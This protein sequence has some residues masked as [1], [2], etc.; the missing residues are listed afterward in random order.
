MKPSTDATSK[1]HPRRSRRWL[2]FSLRTFLLVVAALAV[3]LGIEANQARKQKEAIDRILSLGGSI[4]FDFQVSI[5]EGK[6]FDPNTVPPGPTWLRRLIP[7]EYLDEVTAVNFVRSPVSDSD[8]EVLEHLPR[9]EQVVISECENVT[10]TGFSYLTGLE[11][12]RL[13]NIHATP[14]TDDGLSQVKELRRLER[15]QICGVFTDEGL[16]ELHVMDWLKRLGVGSSRIT[17]SGAEELHAA[18]PN[19]QVAVGYTM[20]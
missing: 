14:V 1:D 2:Q 10:G 11:N 19:T 13:L 8:L 15:L 17:R 12:L 18:L 3:W 6:P 4:A 16:R 9:V 7:S 20:Y 5:H